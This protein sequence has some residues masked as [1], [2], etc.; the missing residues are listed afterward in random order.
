MDKNSNLYIVL[1]AAILTVIVAVVLSLTSEAL[2]APQARNELVDRKTEILKSVGKGEVEDI[3]GF[4]AERIEGR[5]INAQG[6]LVDSADAV[7]VELSVEDKKPSEKRLYPFFIY[8]TDDQT[9]E[10]IVPMR[11]AGLWG[12]IW[13]N[14]ALQS[15]FKT[16]AGVSFGHES[17]TPGLGAEITTDHFQEQYHGLSLYRNDQFVGIDARKGEIRHPENQVR[18]ISGATITSEGVA[19]MIRTDLSNY[20][21]YFKSIE[22]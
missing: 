12:P 19:K 9:K 18:A 6:E 14:M 1:Y 8:T 15:D 11:G 22:E 21:D 13:G 3:E 17:E 16:V 2:K 7:N 20:L 5:V 4:F 10:Y